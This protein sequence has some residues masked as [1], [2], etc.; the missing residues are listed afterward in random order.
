M[1]AS[2]RYPGSATVLLLTLCATLSGC[3][4]NAYERTA[5]SFAEAGYEWRAQGDSTLRDLAPEESARI[6]ADLR[7]CTNDLC[8]DLQNVGSGREKRTVELID[9][10][11]AKGWRLVVREV[12][13]TS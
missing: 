10:M 1:S 3:M 2:I 12:T 5:S 9:C 4:L 6:K 7:Q 8:N 13:V 11:K